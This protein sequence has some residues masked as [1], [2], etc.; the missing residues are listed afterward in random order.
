[1]KL[2]ELWNSGSDQVTGLR[3]PLEVSTSILKSVDESVKFIGRSKDTVRVLFEPNVRVGIG[4]DMSAAS[5]TKS[6][7][8]EY[9]IGHVS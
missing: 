6:E 4:S 9:P 1:M 7:V 5:H 3:S 2:S 8:S